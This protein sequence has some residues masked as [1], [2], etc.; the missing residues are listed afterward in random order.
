MPNS[1]FIAATIG[2]VIGAITN[3][4]AALLCAVS[5]AITMWALTG[6]RTSKSSQTL[7]EYKAESS[8]SKRSTPPDESK[9]QLTPHE[10]GV[11]LAIRLDT[12]CPKSNISPTERSLLVE[13][14]ISLEQ[15]H[16]E[17]LVL[18]ASAQE[19]AIKV[20]LRNSA[21]GQ[22]VLA[23]YQEAWNNVAKSGTV[24]AS[25]YSLYIRRRSAY[26]AAA[27]S[28]REPNN[29]DTI[30]RLPLIFAESLSS[31]IKHPEKSGIAPT[32][33]MLTAQAY[34]DAHY[35]G[36]EQAFKSQ[37]FLNRTDA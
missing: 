34:Y 1:V 36:I 28:D 31:L 13:G 6:F 7:K 8:S 21:V 12:S 35:Q 2:L 20:S 5:F 15:Y 26:E 32:L 30:K 17:V 33:A 11:G 22:Q 10:L 23:G 27:K 16:R 19:H 29:V 3:V 18:C 14:N 24:G 9:I 37:M 4:T 25:L